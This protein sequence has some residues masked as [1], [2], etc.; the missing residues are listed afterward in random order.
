M[1]EVTNPRIRCVILTNVPTPYRAPAWEILGRQDDIE[2]HLI[3]CASPHIAPDQRVHSESHSTHFLQGRY[4]ARDKSFYHSDPKIWSLLND[5][6]PDVV[7]TSGYIPTFLYAF[8]WAVLHGVPHV[9]MTDGTDESEKELSWKHRAV[10]RLVFS[11][12]SAFL[13]ACLGSFRLYRSYRVE[14]TKIHLAPLAIDNAKFSPP[15][16]D[17]AYDLLFCSRF[18]QHKNPLF[19][20]DVADRVARRIGRRVSTRYVGQG[21]LEENIRRRA[22]ELEE[23][24]EVSFAG[25]LSQ[26]QLPLEYAKSRVFLFPTSF[27][28]WGVVVNEACAS[29]LPSLISPHSGAAGELIVDGVQGYVCDVGDIDLWVERCSTLLWDQNQWK[30]MSLA[31]IE[32]VQ[33]FTFDRAAVAVA[34]AVRQAVV[35]RS[36]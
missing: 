12:S 35:A 4:L 24:V 1:G 2:L 36:A 10:R 17:K 23:T 22:M 29:G 3:Y 9:P 18:V 34:D 33:E 11:R 5:L 8:A 7:I 21:A 31:A 25:Y 27:D 14:P 20:L 19:V 32:K 30:K 6:K 16:I 15:D 26:S 28:P 13:G